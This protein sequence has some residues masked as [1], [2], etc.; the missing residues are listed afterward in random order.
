MKER[1]NH[2]KLALGL[3]VFEL[4]VAA[5]LVYVALQVFVF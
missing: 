4:T 1:K 3:L 5:V 2:T